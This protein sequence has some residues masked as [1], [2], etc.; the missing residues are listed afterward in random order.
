MISFRT[1]RACENHKAFDGDPSLYTALRVEGGLMSNTVETLQK[2]EP[3]KQ[4]TYSFD[5]SR[6]L[7]V[8]VINS[9]LS[10]TAL[11]TAVDTT[12]GAG[13]VTVV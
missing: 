8:Q 2:L 3:T 1:L 9:S 11:Q 6:T 7:S 13:K 10:K 12:L 5:E 4:I